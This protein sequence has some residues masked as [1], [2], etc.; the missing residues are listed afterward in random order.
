MIL[1]DVPGVGRVGTLQIPLVPSPTGLVTIL[2][3]CLDADR[4]AF[5]FLN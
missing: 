2:D 1:S 4:D 3:Q 5:D